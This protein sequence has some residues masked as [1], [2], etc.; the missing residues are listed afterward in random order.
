MGVNSVNE[1]RLI[2]QFNNS[3]GITPKTCHY[4]I[5][6]SPA[7][8]RRRRGGRTQRHPP[9]YAPAPTPGTR[10]HTYQHQQPPGGAVRGDGVVRAAVQEGH[11]GPDVPRVVRQGVQLGVR[12]PEPPGPEGQAP[13]GRS[14]RGR[15]RGRGGEV[16]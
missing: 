12:G 8:R 4:A 3:S 1:L 11:A 9:R 10:P 16:R 2:N 14:R 6:W 15:E 5:P 13:H 7:A